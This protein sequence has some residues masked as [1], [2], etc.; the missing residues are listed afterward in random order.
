MHGNIYMYSLI[1]IKNTF[2]KNRKGVSISKSSMHWI[3]N[4]VSSTKNYIDFNNSKSAFVV[5]SSS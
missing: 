3:N 2:V 5:N 4:R 1:L